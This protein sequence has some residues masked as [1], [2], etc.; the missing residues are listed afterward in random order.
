MKKFLLVSLIVVLFV[1]SLTIVACKE[2]IDYQSIVDSYVFEYEGKSV[3]E[4][5]TLPL[6]IKDFEVEWKSN[7]DVVT[8]TKEKD[9]WLA[10]ITS[11][12]EQ[13]VEVTLTV[14]LNDAKRDFTIIIPDKVQSLIDSYVFENEGKSVSEDFT[15][16]SEIGGFEVEWITSDYSFLNIEKRTDDYLVRVTLSD[17]LERN[18]NITL[19]IG[20]KTKTYG[21]NV[22]MQESLLSKTIVFYSTQGD[23]LKAITQMAISSF[24][25]KFPDWKVMHVQV[26]GY[27]DLKERVGRNLNDGKQ[28]DIAYCYGE[29]VPEYIESSKIINLNELIKSS[30]TVLGANKTR[31]AVG[32]ENDEIADFIYDYYQEG[33]ASNY[34]DYD[35]YGYAS[36]DLLTI[37]FAKSSELMY[38]NKT[39]L[40]SLGL[41]PAQTWEELW[42]QCEII[43]LRYPTATPLAYDSESN[44]FITTCRQNGWGYT[45]ASAPHYLFNN[46]NTQAW[47]RQLSDY[48]NQGYVTTQNTYSGYTS[49]LFI[50]GADNGGAIYCI[51][52]SSGA[53]YLYPGSLF[54]CGVA[55][56]P[57]TKLADGSINYSTIAQGPSLVMFEPGYNVE[58]GDEKKIMTFLFMKELLS[59]NFQAAFSMASVSNPVRSSVYTIPSYVEYVNGN[60]I[61]SVTARVSY[62]M[63]GRYFTSP[64]FIGA[65]TARSQVGNAMCYS[66]TGS[67]TPEKALSDAIDGC[68]GKTVKNRN[69]KR[70]SEIIRLFLY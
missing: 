33:F 31:Y 54:E 7:S 68:N 13:S 37:P 1:C 45:S 17:L 41:S 60:D 70:L 30:E 59:P 65:S 14:I 23:R 12:E 16:P 42:S 39:A 48:Y 15:L 51:S 4:D 38:F 18:V 40:D 44:W 19:R 26:G 61:V 25:A 36:T 8:L 58:N 64:S 29:H 66:L 11:T 22:V 10:E 63:I 5:F 34:G 6:S 3:S 56:V 69:V 53:S 32:Y 57:G 49:S 9:C 47:L 62:Y 27:D 35:K 24:E 55:P 50:R 46:V 21:F 2:K 20:E 28:P 43:K 52:S 67:K